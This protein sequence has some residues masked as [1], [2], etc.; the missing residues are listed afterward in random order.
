MPHNDVSSWGKEMQH[1]INYWSIP[2]THFTDGAR[3][4]T[5]S[6]SIPTTTK[7]P[8]VWLNNVSTTD[9][10]GAWPLLLHNATIQHSLYIFVWAPTFHL[11]LW[12]RVHIAK[13]A[14]L[15]SF[16]LQKFCKANRV[17]YN[18]IQKT[19]L[20]DHLSDTEGL[21]GKFGAAIC[22]IWLFSKR[23]LQTFVVF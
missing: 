8:Q 4:S 14:F 13:W 3:S 11:L 1:V 2:A 20:L 17:T 15:W 23:H 16:K 10:V 9:P 19:F 12:V 18:M 5:S 21:R 22:H 6:E 7:E